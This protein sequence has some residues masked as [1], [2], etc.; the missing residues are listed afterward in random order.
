MA[1][2]IEHAQLAEL[3]RL[4][5]SLN[6]DDWIKELHSPNE[7]EIAGCI[8]AT[9]TE[10]LRGI[11]L[12]A[13]EY[14]SEFALRELSW[15]AANGHI[16]PNGNYEY[17]EKYPPCVL[18]VPVYKGDWFVYDSELASKFPDKPN[19]GDSRNMKIVKIV[20]GAKTDFVI[21]NF[22]ES[23]DISGKNFEEIKESFNGYLHS[24]SEEKQEIFKDS[25]GQVK[26][27]Q[28]WGACT[29]GKI[30]KGTWKQAAF[31]DQLRLDLDNL[32]GA[33]LHPTIF[34]NKGSRRVDIP[35]QFQLVK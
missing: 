16:D 2:L 24:I 23:N 1:T 30:Y 3:D 19:V 18:D 4:N 22:L 27:V 25:P 33:T 35:K 9:D 14:Y 29:V 31:P 26:C 32:P 15:R 28:R 20:T 7:I 21:R 11:S 12:L 17:A 5:E 10:T 6:T 8:K 13:R 34:Y